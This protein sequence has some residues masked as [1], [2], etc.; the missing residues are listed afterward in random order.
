M[1]I[2]NKFIKNFIFNVFFY[3]III[4]IISSIL[5]YFYVSQRYGIPPIYGQIDWERY[6]D[7][8]LSIL[9]FTLPEFPARYYL[10]YCI[11]LA[12]SINIKFPIFS[13]ILNLF[14]NLISAIL[15]YKIS[16]LLFNKI[17][18]LICIILFLFY[19]FIQMWVFFIQPVS[20][21]SFSIILLTYAVVT[22]NKHNQ[23][24]LLIFISSS[25]KLKIPFS[26]F[27]KNKVPECFYP[28]Y[29][30]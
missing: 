7:G 27:V 2:K 10:S 3:I 23:N 30:F 15:I 25:D 5:F 16:E 1:E 17:S 29:I 6:K 8:A 24:Y 21:F 22:T 28:S 12:I 13:L 11:Y 20:Y 26:N 14:L 19:P 18:A 9:N 4:W